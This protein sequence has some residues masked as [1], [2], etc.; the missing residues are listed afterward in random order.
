MKK[1]SSSFRDPSGF[2]FYHEGEI[3]RQV[4]HIYKENY[5]YLLNSGLYQLLAE[6]RLLLPHTEVALTGEASSKAYK[7][8]KP[9]CLPFIS[10]PYEWSFS[11]LKHAALLTLEIQETS[12]KYGMS[13]CDSSAYNIQFWNGR[14]VLIDSLSFEKY[15][16]NFPWVAYRQ[17][18]QHFLAPLALMS[19]RDVR[20]NRLLQLFIDGILLD[21]ASNLLPWRTSLRLSL[22]FNIHLH[23][24]SQKYFSGMTISNQKAKMSKVA[25]LGLI[26]CLREVVNGLN[27]HNQKTAWG[28]YYLDTNYS[29]EAFAD[30][31]RVINLFLDEIHPRWVWDWGANNGVFSR[32][33]SKK[34]IPTVA[35]DVDPA[36]VEIN[37]LKC[38]EEK[39]TNLLP[40]LMDVTNPSP[41]IGWGNQERLSLPGRGPVDCLLVLAIIHHLVIANNLPMEKIAAFF[42]SI[43]SWLIIEFVPKNDSQLQRLLAC[44]KDIFSNYTVEDF[45]REFLSYFSIRR[46]VALV[47]SNRVI[48]LMKKND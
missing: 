23:A 8:L 2:V 5:D 32:I 31:K 39:E 3:Y 4:N 45:E 14:A 13:L 48:Y 29:A 26:D 38:L 9:K 33:A 24:R 30:K 12:L 7:I 47:D 16:E 41:G 36:A 28:N 42:A 34:G 43:T 10:Y 27:W 25:L 21:L 40:L 20:L 44:R 6:K 46:K 11:Q 15:H 18:C 1:E 19:Y 37:Y 35:L 17:F 22:L